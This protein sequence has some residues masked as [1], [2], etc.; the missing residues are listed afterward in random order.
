MA[1]MTIVGVL[2]ISQAFACKPLTDGIAP[3]TDNRS[4][5]RTNMTP[6]QNSFDFDSRIYSKH[7]LVGRYASLATA[8]FFDPVANRTQYA[9]CVGIVTFDGRGRFTDR[10]VHSYDGVIVRDEFVGTYT[11]NG[12]G[13]GTMHFVG[14]NETYDYEFIVSNDAKDITFLVLLDLPGVVSNGTLKKQ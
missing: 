6:A 11:L 3:R 7:D 2:G 4:I 10:E 13:R 9:T 1:L 12:D 8:T 5:V 14:E